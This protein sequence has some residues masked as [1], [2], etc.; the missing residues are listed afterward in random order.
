MGYRKKILFFFKQVIVAKVLCL[1]PP[2]N[3]FRMKNISLL[4][5]SMFLQVPH[6]LIKWH[7]EIEYIKKI[8]NNVHG[9]LNILRE[10]AKKS[11]Y[12]YEIPH[13]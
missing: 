8:L 13:G 7:P 3:R 2:Y 12:L 11:K 5:D 9:F 10:G 6:I 4:H 1:L